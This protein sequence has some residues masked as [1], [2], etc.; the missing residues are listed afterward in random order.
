MNNFNIEKKKTVI[1][2][3][4]YYT[5]N[6]ITKK[7]SIRRVGRFKIHFDQCGQNVHCHWY[8]YIV[9]EHEKN[10]YVNYE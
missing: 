6:V 1:T 5:S 7:N 8:T 2:N 9:Y 3:K 4:K 10:M